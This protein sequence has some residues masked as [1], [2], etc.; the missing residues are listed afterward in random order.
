M[1]GGQDKKYSDG[2]KGCGCDAIKMRPALKSVSHKCASLSGVGDLQLRR[3]VT[4][5]NSHSSSNC[6]LHRCSCRNSVVNLTRLNKRILSHYRRNSLTHPTRGHDVSTAVLIITI[7][8]FFGHSHHRNPSRERARTIAPYTRTRDPHRHPRHAQTFL[9]AQSPRQIS[10]ISQRCP[11]RCLKLH[12]LPRKA[13]FHQE[14][15]W[16]V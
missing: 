1:R 12:H 4:M 2:D 14:N 11:H 15:L 16:Q 9:H 7:G 8:L 13:F 5:L 6:P 10:S 3:H